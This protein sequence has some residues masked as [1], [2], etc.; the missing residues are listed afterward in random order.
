M[1]DDLPKELIFGLLTAIVVG[2]VSL[3]WKRGRGKFQA[4]IRG[5]SLAVRFRSLGITQ[6]YGSRSDY[7][8]YR[9]AARLID[10][11]SLA[12]EQ[13]FVL[14]YWLAQGAEM[15][16]VVDGLERLIRT[17]PSLRVSVMVIDPSSDYINSVAIGMGLSRESIVE[18]VSETLRGLADLQRRLGTHDGQRVS[19]LLH[20]S[21]PNISLIA[22]DPATKKG[23]IQVD[24]K[25]FGIPRSRSI[26]FE[27]RG[28]EMP[29]YAAA[30]ESCQKLIDQGKTLGRPPLPIPLAPAE[31]EAGTD[32]EPRG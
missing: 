19:I 16:G 14:G 26:S 12:D 17:K 20:P 21:Q 30:W 24:L 1:I 22:L 28:A 2:I 11:L 25:L 3:T 8:K 29:I 10:Y 4:F 5:I 15:E 13:V 27:C 23:R 9:K 18:R 7:A 6:I 31:L 32:D